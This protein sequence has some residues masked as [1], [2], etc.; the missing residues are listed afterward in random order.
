MNSASDRRARIALVV[1]AMALALAGCKS[2][3][4]SGLNETEANEIVAALSG[5]G[6]DARK[7]R[8]EGEQWQVQVDE[9]RVGAALEL[10]KSQGLPHER[11]ASIGDMFRK[12]GLV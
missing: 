6:I 2:A 7:E 4:Y 3:L 8:L 11:F 10:L 1:C 9:G 12:Q 5:G